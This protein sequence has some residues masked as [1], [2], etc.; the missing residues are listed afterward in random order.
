MY[1]PQH[2]REDRVPVLHDAMRRISL[3]TLVTGAAGALEASHL[4]LL[5]DPD[6]AP[7]GT[8]VSHLARDNPHWQRAGDG[9][10]LAIFLG[11]HAYVSPAW[12]PSKAKDGRVVPTWNYVAVHAYGRLEF[13]DD[14]V[15]LRALVARLT[16]VHEG[17]RAKP[18]SIDDAPEDYV[19]MM[20][21]AIV[22][23]T[24]P[25]ARLEGKWKMSQNRPPGDR[26][27]AADGL[28][29]E[30]AAEVGEIVRHVL[31]GDAP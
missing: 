16:A 4:P 22:G 5:L 25:I 29:D 13:F 10:G 26:A 14:A 15:R 17:A 9:D 1:V 8:L 21:T 28:R 7:Y 19:Q 11:P 12:Y 27:G 23:F 6:P 18:W 31:R 2:F 24:L 20:L 30:G 3:A